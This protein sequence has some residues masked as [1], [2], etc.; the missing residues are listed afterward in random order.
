VLAEVSLPLSWACDLQS[1]RGFENSTS[2]PLPAI[3]IN[4]RFS[5]TGH[6]IPI[7]YLKEYFNKITNTRDYNTINREPQIIRSG[8]Q[9]LSRHMPGWS[10]FR[11]SQE[12]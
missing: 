2:V 7:I 10:V 8:C 11:I 6:R 1:A 9:Q 4:G 5:T 12:F 3:S